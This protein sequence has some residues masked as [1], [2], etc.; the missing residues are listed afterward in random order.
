MSARQRGKAH[1]HL[2]RKAVCEK[3]QEPAKSDARQIDIER[4][5]MLIKLGDVLC[6]QLLQNPLIRS[7]G[8][9]RRR[10]EVGREQL[11]D[12]TNEHPICLFFLSARMGQ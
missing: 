2:D 9:Q 10:V 7:T 4:D 3:T 5:Q 6:H 12:Q 11:V 8:E 1:T